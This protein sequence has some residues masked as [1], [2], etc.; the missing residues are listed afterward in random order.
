MSHRCS[1][2]YCNDVHLESPLEYRCCTEVQPVANLLMF[3]GSIENASCI[4]KHPDFEVLTNKAV[5]KQVAP[6][7]KGKQGQSYR[8]LPGR[9]ENE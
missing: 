2:S 1:C 9:S 8:Q 4:T 3:D 6:L 5:L 7:L